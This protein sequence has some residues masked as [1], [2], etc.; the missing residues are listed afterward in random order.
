MVW[1]YCVA[2]LVTCGLMVTGC[3]AVNCQDGLLGLSPTHPASSCRDIHSCNSNSTT[4]YY[5]I[6]DRPFSIHRQYCSMEEM[7]C[8]VHGG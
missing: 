4:G 7:R 6:W 5:W 1:K 8:G 2:L 3:A